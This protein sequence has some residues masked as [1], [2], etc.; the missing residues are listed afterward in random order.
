MLCLIGGVAVGCGTD[1]KGGTTLDL[2]DASAPVGVEVV[3]TVSVGFV[4]L[5][6]RVVNSYRVAVPAGELQ[7]TASGSNIEGGSITQALD[8]SMTGVATARLAAAGPGGAAFSVTSADIEI[9]LT[10]AAGPAWTTEL[11]MS[12]FAAGTANM[13][14]VSGIE[15]TASVTGT[16]GVAVAIEDEVWWNSAEPGVPP[17]VV[18]DMPQNIAGM[19]SGHVD[20]DGV[21]DLAVWGGNQ[22]LVLRGLDGGG[23]T[24]GAGWRAVDGNVVGVS[25]SDADSDRIRDVSVGTSGGGG[26]VVT[27]FGHDGAWGFSAYEELLVNSELYSIAVG[28]ET[29]D[30]RP[31]VSVF[32]TVTGTIRRYTLADEGWVG[33]Q[34]SELPNFE[35]LDGGVLLPLGDLDGDG[36]L[37]TIIEGSPDAN[38]QDLVFYV[39]DP[40]GQG[41]INYPQS[42]GVYESTVADLDVNGSPDIVIVEDGKLTVIGWDGEAFESRTSQGADLRGPV[43]AGD[44]TG[45]GLPDVSV[46]TDYLR[47]Y[48]GVISDEGRWQRDD[49]GWLTYPTSYHPSMKVADVNG[50][51]A[52]DLVGLRTD[53]D[54]GEV[55]M[56]AW[57]IDTSTDDPTP[58]PL[59]TVGLI[60]SSGAALDLVV[61]DGEVYALSEGVDDDT[62]GTAAEIRLTLVRF[63]DSTGAVKVNEITVERGAMLDCGTIDNGSFG[64]VVSNDIGFW[65]SYGRELGV[66][67][68]GDVGATED[69]AL[70]DTNGDGLG[71]VVGCPGDGD[72]CSVIALDLDGDG[73]DEVIRSTDRTIVSNVAGDTELSGRGELVVADVDG[74]GVQDILGWDAG[75]G[76]LHAWRNVGGSLAPSSDLHTDPAL[77]SLAGL[78]D[79]TGDGVPELIFVDENGGTTHST[80]TVAADGAAW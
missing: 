41:S 76:I 54:T 32:A 5:K 8:A 4:E 44:V 67:G 23:Y 71:E 28:D 25:I 16:G 53:P 31:D 19:A 12:E 6:A 29:G 9:D 55:D 77:Q 70:A 69:I 73:I 27:V 62:A 45:D 26:G 64:V 7:V 10:D 2:V 30:G 51:G 20:R 35:S 68:S 34:T 14:G 80:A 13:L 48:P 46:V 17:Y 22:A 52:A 40:S 47:H 61:C 36:V 63:A 72:V 18:A 50:D 74:D 38:T 24:W 3:P 11:S 42:Y 39:I 43:S 58:S 49:F 33:A 66:V 75:T 21:L 37:E 57:E 1:D 59:G 65:T 15:P 78:A 79:M 60:A 56:T